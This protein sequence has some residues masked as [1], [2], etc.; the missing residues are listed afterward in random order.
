MLWLALPSAV[1]YAQEPVLQATNPVSNSHIAPLTTTVVATYNQPMQ[2]SSVSTQTFA[3]H[4]MKTGQL[5]QSFSVAGNQLIVTPPNS[6]KPG[7]LVQVSATT[8][9]TNITGTNPLTPTVW[10]FRAKA[11]VGPA[12]FDVFKA[13][14]GSGV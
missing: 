3:V 6:L 11:G 12:V 7:E 4:A 10:Q 14:F 1:A 8:G 13:T 2:A 5:T 9:T